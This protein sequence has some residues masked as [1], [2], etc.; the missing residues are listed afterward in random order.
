MTGEPEERDGE[1][2]L[3]P[4]LAALV[5]T[6]LSVLVLFAVTILR[7]GHRVVLAPPAPRPIAAATAPR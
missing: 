2:D 3:D 4:I 7:D 6:V 1:P 5:M